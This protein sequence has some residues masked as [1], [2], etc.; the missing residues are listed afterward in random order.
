MVYYKHLD[1]LYHET[2]FAN[3]ILK[4]QDYVKQALFAVS[5]A[6]T[7]VQWR[8]EGVS[9]R[10]QTL[11]FPK[12]R[13]H[14]EFWMQKVHEQIQSKDPIF[15][16]YPDE[17]CLDISPAFLFNFLGP[18]RM[19]MHIRLID[20]E[21]SEVGWIMPPE[22]LIAFTTV[23]FIHFLD[24]EVNVVQGKVQWQEIIGSKG[25]FG[26]GNIYGKLNEFAYNH[27]EQYIATNEIDFE[28]YDLIDSVTYSEPYDEEE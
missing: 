11:Q 9:W 4:M 17:P 27:V 1:P 19:N 22:E 2:Q 10:G 21:N 20:D 28:E 13:N 24:E 14:Y 25:T 26:Y 16:D 15:S 3:E 18:L 7:H 5:D 23:K 12:A 8:N 6:E